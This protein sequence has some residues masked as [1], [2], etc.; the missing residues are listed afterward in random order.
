[1][2]VVWRATSEVAVVSGRHERT[3][4]KYA[5]EHIR[6]KKS[7]NAILWPCPAILDAI[8]AAPE[9][10]GYDF[11]KQRLTKAQADKTEIETEVLRENLIPR[12]QVVEW[13]G[14][15]VSAARAVAIHP[16][17]GRGGGRDDER[18]RS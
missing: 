13:Y 9:R 10:K 17:E 14:R 3:V 2:A 5:R 18:I 15:M 1:M 11:E 6:S 8:Y 12:E 4:K 16:D 7:G